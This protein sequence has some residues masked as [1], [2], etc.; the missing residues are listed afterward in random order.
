M[1][2]RPIMLPMLLTLSAAIAGVVAWQIST[3]SDDAPLPRTPLPQTRAEPGAAP[4]P[5]EPPG[6]AAAWAAT[7]LARPP[8][9]PDRRPPGP[10][11]AAPAL[12]DAPL[13]RLTGILVTPE[14]RSAIFAGQPQPTVVRE[15]G[16][17]GRF[18]VQRI[19]PGQVILA[20][21]DGPR[22]LRPAFDAAAPPSQPASLPLIPGA[23]PVQGGIPPAPPGTIPSAADTSQDAMP[24]ETMTSPTGAAILREQA[25]RETSPAPGK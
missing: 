17:L 18:S 25:R 24:F 5:A 15:G 22:I 16:I 9:S 6:Q 1:T 10:G 4:R 7:L 2:D 3:L 11:A 14:G 20:G 19:E 13:P 21:P 8:F 12:P 23:R